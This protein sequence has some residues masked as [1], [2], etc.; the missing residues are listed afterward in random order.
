M[1][2]NF[3]ELFQKNGHCVLNLGYI[4]IKNKRQMKSSFPLGEEKYS[5]STFFS[6]KRIVETIIEKINALNTDLVICHNV[7]HKY[8]MADLL[9]SIKERTTAT[10]MMVFHDYKPVCPRANLYNGK[11]ICTDCSGGRF[12]NMSR[13]RC[14]NNSFLESSLLVMDSYYNNTFRDAYQ[15]PDIF[16][17]PS[18][19][20]AEQFGKMGFS[21]KI[22]VINNPI[23][24]DDIP[25]HKKIGPKHNTLLFAGRLTKDKGVEVYIDT[26]R[27][28]PEFNFLIA[29]HGELLETV[30]N[31]D[32][33]IKN[34]HYLGSLSK[35]QLLEQFEIA[36]YL[37]IPSIWYENNPMIIIEAMAFGLPVL[38]SSLGGIPELMN[39]ERGFLFDPYQN[40][41]LEQRIRE[42]NLLPDEIYQATAERARVFSSNFSYDRYFEKLCLIIPQLSNSEKE[43]C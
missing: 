40:G 34:I 31:A 32:R 20:L 26:A 4:S 24:T 3:T 37:V 36:D 15:Y 29:G 18:T 16:I 12:Y 35:S 17:S 14:R 19:F 6:E 21:R 1:M 9:K 41:S 42:L 25:F 43:K 2:S 28:M 8:P 22:N 38:A 33:E 10:I 5:V 39:G 11:R 30:K 23:D 13:H 7:Y 27:S